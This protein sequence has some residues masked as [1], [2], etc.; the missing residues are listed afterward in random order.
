MSATFA[1]RQH[2]AVA[3]HVGGPLRQRV[4]G[5]R[6]LHAGEVVAHQQRL[7]GLGEVM[8]LVGRIMIALHRAFEMGH[9][10]RALDGQI[11]VVFHNCSFWFA[12]HCRA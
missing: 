11:V 9:E 7:A 4:L 5:Q 2:L 10:I 6:L 8:D 3:P 1:H 12:C